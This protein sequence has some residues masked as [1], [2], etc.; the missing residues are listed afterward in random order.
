MNNVVSPFLRALGRSHTYNLFRNPEAW[1]GILWGIP[2]PVFSIALDRALVAGQHRSLA[3]ILSEP[4][5]HIA[6]LAHPLLFAVIFGAMGTIRRD[7]E[8]GNRELI[9]RLGREA[10]T[11]PLTGAHNRRYVLEEL[12]KALSRAGRSAEPIAVVMFDMD[13]FKVVNDSLGHPL[14]DQLNRD[15][16][17]CHTSQ[18]KGDRARDRP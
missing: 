7:L 17:E 5:W 18:A 12:D 4:P 9:E 3:L 1:F 2:I 15:I 8:T 16:E 11:D 10:T 6:F 13:N 14:G